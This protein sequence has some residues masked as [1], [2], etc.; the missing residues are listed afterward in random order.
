MV[1]KRP[2]SNNS[3]LTQK[4]FSDFGGHKKAAGFSVP[5]ENLD[6]FVDGV[7]AYVAKYGGDTS[8]NFSDSDITSEAFLNKSDINILAPLAPFGEGNPAPILT[9]G[10]N[11][12]TINNRF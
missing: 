4:Y 10:I 8:N 5:R 11:L 1:H 6:S 2:L 3:I 7:V 9:D 12:Y